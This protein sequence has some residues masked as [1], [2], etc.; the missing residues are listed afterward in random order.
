MRSILSRF[1]SLFRKSVSPGTR[2]ATVEIG[3]TGPL[4]GQW[5]CKLEIHAMQ[6]PRRDALGL[7]PVTMTPRRWALLRRVQAAR[8]RQ[9][10]AIELRPLRS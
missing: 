8:D 9:L 3:G 6:N 4:A 10:E 7:P 1:L 2:T 5:E